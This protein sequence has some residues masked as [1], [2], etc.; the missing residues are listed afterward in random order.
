[1]ICVVGDRNPRLTDKPLT[2]GE[3]KRIRESTDERG[4]IGKK[5]P[6]YINTNVEYLSH[7]MYYQWEFNG[8][9]AAT[10]LPNYPSPFLRSVQET[11]DLSDI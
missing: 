11:C 7:N 1:M 4:H 8:V 10:F 3:N 5:V 6:M 2:L 9:P